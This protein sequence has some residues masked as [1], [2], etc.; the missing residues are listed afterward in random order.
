MTSV[1]TARAAVCRTFGAPLIIEAIEVAAPGPGEVRVAIGEVPGGV[2]ARL[3]PEGEEA[4]LRAAA[5]S[6]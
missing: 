3:V 5:G 6:G 1:V 2:E 4:A